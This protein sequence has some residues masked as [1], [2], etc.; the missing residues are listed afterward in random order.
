MAGAAG[1][2]RPT[3]YRWFPTK[4]ELLAAISA[5][6]EERFDIGLQR[7]ID[8]DPDAETTTGRRPAVPH[9]LPRR[10]DDARSDRR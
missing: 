2:S 5:Y 4:E 10:V 9:A 6:E 8:V 3:L 1:I 7:V